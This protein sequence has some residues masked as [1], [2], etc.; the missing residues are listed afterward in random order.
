MAPTFE[1]LDFLDGIEARVGEG[2]LREHLT[3]IAEAGVNFFRQVMPLMMMSWSNPGP[4]GLPEVLTQPNP[5]PLRALRK[6]AELLRG[7]DPARPPAPV[8]PRDP[9]PHLP[10]RRPAVRLLRARH[11][12]PARP[13][14]AAADLPARPGR[15][16]VWTA[17]ARSPPTPPSPGGRHDPSPPPHA[18]F[19]LPPR[20]SA[21]PRPPAAPGVPRSAKKHNFDNREAARDRAP[22]R[23]PGRPG[24]MGPDPHGQRDRRLHAQPVRG[25]GHAPRRR[26]T[27]PTTRTITPFNQL[28][29]QLTLTQ[30]IVDLAALRNIDAAKRNL[31]AGT[32]RIA[33]TQP[34]VDQ[35]VAQT[36]FQVVAA[37]AFIRATE[38]V[39][40]ATRPTSR[41]SSSGPP[42]ASPPT[43]TAAAPRSRS[44]AAARRSPTPS[45][46]LRSPA[47]A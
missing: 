47:S 46:T 39:H 15:R 33:A 38:E 28:D 6:L 29:A 12:G 32:A 37:E 5:P 14:A 34:Q 17:P 30:P 18:L 40:A 20:P 43:S 35:A 31:S 10:R 25:Q 27:N 9:R 36:Y 13:A 45:T 1:T 8:R 26:P 44:S 2:D 3:Q 4:T 11:Q 24:K 19:A 41:S 42:P 21:G 16:I 22:A 7:R 23:A